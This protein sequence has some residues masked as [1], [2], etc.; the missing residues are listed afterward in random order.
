MDRIELD[1]LIDEAMQ[2]HI[3]LYHTEG[4]CPGGFKPPTR[5]EVLAFCAEGGYNVDPDQFIDFYAAKGWKVGK[6][7]MKDWRAAVGKAAREGWCKPAP[8]KSPV[9]IA[10]AQRKEGE[11]LWELRCWAHDQP[12]EKLLEA[13]RHAG[14]PGFNITPRMLKVIDEVLMERRGNH[15]HI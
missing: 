14:D 7:T 15:G 1:Q 6:V 5:E 4:R 10:R 12:T 13:K 3:R 8:G 9:S 11:D 2:R